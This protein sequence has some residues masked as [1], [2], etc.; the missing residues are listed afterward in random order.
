VVEKPSEPRASLEAR[1][2]IGGGTARCD[3]ADA[4]A[5]IDERGEHGTGTAL[6][7]GRLASRGIGVG[8]FLAAAAFAGGVF[9]EALG[10]DG[11]GGCGADVMIELVFAPRSSVTGHA[12]A[13]SVALRSA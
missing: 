3:G 11:R 4:G 12:S 8:V 9:P 13:S 2:G 1:A 7:V 10:F 5:E 6:G